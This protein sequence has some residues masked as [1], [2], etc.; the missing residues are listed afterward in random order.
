MLVSIIIRT[1]NEESY[2]D[3]LLCAI[4]TQNLDNFICETIVVDSGSIDNTLAIAEAHNV[5]IAHINKQD[6][7]FGR[8]LNVGCEFAN[9]E[10][11]VFISGHCIP[12]NENW[13]KNLVSPLIQKK[14]DYSYG[15]QIGRDTTKISEKQV[16]DQYFPNNASVSQ[17]NFYCN[18]ANAAVTRVAWSKYQFDEELTG[19]EDMFMAKQICHDNGSIGYVC[20]SSVYHIHD[21]SWM[22][23]KIRY[24]R[25][26]IA[27]QKIM[28][29][30]RM[31]ILD[32]FHFI[33]ASIL[34]DIGIAIHQGVFV[35][36]LPS[37]LMFR[38]LQYYG[39]YKGSRLCRKLSYEAK[40]KY[41]YPRN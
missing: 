9:G 14:C 8:S 31:N 18:N 35:R 37:I 33:V 41:F 25:E 17:N 28:P 20:E 39:S 27:L 10:Y 32:M 7:T 13:V 40:I 23:I 12:T 16:F 22:Q 5:R 1:L 4:D 26:A 29:E 36:E 34:K 6:F 19:L 30:V 15:R 21:E 24:E 3:E 38:V 11:L 2:L